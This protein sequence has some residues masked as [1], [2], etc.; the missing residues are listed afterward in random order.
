MCRVALVTCFVAACFQPSHGHRATL[1]RA[2]TEWAAHPRAGAVRV[3]V[4]ARAD[5]AENVR[6]RLVRHGATSV[7]NAAH[8]ALF[9]CD[10]TVAALNA[11]VTDRDVLHISSDSMVR[12]LETSYLDQDVLLGTEALLPRT[13][14]GANVGVAVIDS[15]ILP[16][17]NEKVVATYDFITSNGTKVG[18]KDPYG[19]G[20]HVSGLIASTGKTSSD[21]YEGIAPDTR[22][23]AL[24]ALTGNGAGYT[25]SVINAI[26]FA[27]AQ[28]TKLGIDILNL[29]LG[30]P[31][32]EPAST[33]PLVQAVQRA[34]DAGIV[35]VVSAG[36][37]GGDPT[38]HVVGYGGITSPANA[39]NAITVGAVETVQTATRA[40]DI[41]AWYSSRGP[42]WYDGFQKPDL[43]APGS[44]LVS[45]VPTSSAI[46][47]TYPRGLIKTSGTTNLTKL[48]GTSM[49][50]GVVSGVV[51]LMIDANRRNYP[52]GHLTPQ[53]IKAMLEYSALPIAG[54]DT[55]S[56]GAGAVNAAGAVRLAASTDTRQP[57]GAWWLMS[58][59]DT[60]SV[61]GGEILAWGQH[62]VWGDHIVWAD[63]VFRNDPAWGQHI[64]W[65]DHLV[66]GDTALSAH[67][68][69]WDDGSPAVWGSH[70]VWGDSLIGEATSSGTMWGNLSTSV[71]ADHI[72]WGDLSSLAIAPTALSW[73]N[74]EQAN[75]D[76]VAK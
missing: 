44:H 40:D 69:V 23:I 62:I 38:T 14:T 53:A 58:P 47:T 70:I 59:V 54:Y 76:L 35:V 32:Y 7:T 28:R 3:L 19:H 61:I 17:A 67:S 25:S 22:L 57:N 8:T 60:W 12:S 4:Q 11:I 66:W 18:A 74:L 48:S 41:V 68:T 15:G 46:A 9:T 49:A 26:D 29:S 43:V 13:Y 2:L 65:G 31:I 75:G 42:T 51:S 55:L 73:S 10:V 6:E 64:I 71:S 21:L 1:D 30:H 33:D 27:I 39:P 50:A 24:R 20:T 16:N 63:R 72:V 5:A 56:Q 36:N 52:G 34:V 45:D 37:F